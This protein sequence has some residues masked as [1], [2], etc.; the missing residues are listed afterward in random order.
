MPSKEKEMK[1]INFYSYKGGVGRTMLTAQIARILAALGNKVVIVDFDFDAPG[2]PAAF[3]IDIAKELPRDK[4]EK[5][6]LFELAQMFTF[7]DNTTKKFL[8]YYT[9]EDFT[10]EF[11][12]TL[13]DVKIELA[14]KNSKGEA[15][16]IKI[17]PS[18][19]ADKPYWEAIFNPQWATD[20]VTEPSDRTRPSFL[21][22]FREYII[23]ELKSMDIDYL[24]IDARAGISHYGR[25]A[26]L[27]SH[28]QVI[29]LSPNRE[30]EEVVDSRFWGMFEESSLEK[31]PLFIVS[32][33]PPEFDEEKEQIFNNLQTKIIDQ[34]K[35]RD[36]LKL[37]S[38][39]KLHLYPQIRN[40]NR[41]YLKKGDC[42][43][44]QIHEDILKIFVALC[45]NEIS[46]NPVNNKA[47]AV[48]NEIYKKN[49]F[50]IT[51]RHRLFGFME[52]IGE[53]RNMDGKRNIAFKTETFLN[54]L[55]SFYDTLKKNYEDEG[56]DKTE[57]EKKAEVLMRKALYD[58]GLECGKAFGASI[59][60]Q[61]NE[62]G[63][64]GERAQNIKRWCKFDSDAGFGIMEYCADVDTI[65]IRNLFIINSAIDKAR[66]YDEFFKGY[67]KGV[68]YNLLGTDTIK[69]KY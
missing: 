39:L 43:I 52:Y 30:T 34:F 66:G 49:P 20:L 7:S 54:L 69:A 47:H 44:V 11:K 19:R 53:M 65:E 33:M 22:F 60:K 10:R 13:I 68:E 21:R 50:E 12:K 31:P 5:K 67:V 28:N 35:A 23:E 24:L 37:H 17:L 59:Y 64:Y 29:I 16:Y 27:V 6:G 9:A 3:G 4:P 1:I 38:D 55:N 42:E 41:R 57:A 15:G 48:W 14:G 61:W 56:A 45:S 36:I 2:I 18:G 46:E 51:F 25:I 40:F 32:R 62:E 58:A 26:N 8:E 63:T